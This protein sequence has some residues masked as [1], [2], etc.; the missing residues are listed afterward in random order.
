MSPEPCV[1]GTLTQPTF[2]PFAGR[3]S[4]GPGEEPAQLM[5]SVN[6]T[7]HHDECQRL[8]LLNDRLQEHGG[9]IHFDTR[10]GNAAH[11]ALS[12]TTKTAIGAQMPFLR[13]ILGLQKFAVPSFSCTYFDIGRCLRPN[14]KQWQLSSRG[15]AAGLVLAKR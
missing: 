7:S 15:S 12:S 11:R 13:M 9:H 3:T 14:V 10:S 8:R 2:N 1:T 5:Y 6:G 4:K